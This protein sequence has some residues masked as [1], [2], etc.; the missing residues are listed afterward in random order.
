MIS[1]FSLAPL[2]IL[3]ILLINVALA[4]GCVSEEKTATIVIK[5]KMYNENDGYTVLDAAGSVYDVTSEGT[6]TYAYDWKSLQINHTYQC[7]LIPNGLGEHR[8]IQNCAEVLP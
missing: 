7:T 3:G 1:K 2:I 6:G 4:P 8:W 5:D